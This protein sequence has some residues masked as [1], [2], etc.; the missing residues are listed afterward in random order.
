MTVTS[1]EIYN[2]GGTTTINMT[3]SGGSSP[4]SYNLNDGLYQ[5][6]NIFYYIKAG[7]YSVGSK[8]INGCMT[9]N[10][11]TITEPTISATSVE[12]VVRDIKVYPNPSN[13]F[14]TVSF[15]KKHKNRNLYLRVV[16]VQGNIK[17]SASGNTDMN[18]VFGYNFTPGT[19]FLKVYFHGKEKSITLIKL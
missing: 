9:N 10:S 8:D 14:F 16:D 17:F 4:F 19:Y 5:T 7:V 12:T 11:I 1:G 3:T 6:S 2:A 18:F 13:S 15:S